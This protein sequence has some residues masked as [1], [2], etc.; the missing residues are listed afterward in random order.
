MTRK[1]I[2]W[3]AKEAGVNVQ[4]VLYYERRGLLPTPARSMNGYRVFNDASVR[5]IRFIKRAQE[6]GFTLKKVIALLALQGEQDAS[7]ADVSAMAANHL[8]D[9][10]AK[11]H[12]LERMKK[13]LIPLVEA[14]PKKG[15]LKACPIMDSM[16][17]DK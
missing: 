11:I 17:G 9:I 6:L 10:E 12:D 14:C 1:T 16:E 2:G 3:V 4:T 7:C 15:A 13:A 8:E 5:R